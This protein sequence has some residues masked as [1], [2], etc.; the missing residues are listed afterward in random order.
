[1]A[2]SGCNGGGNDNNITPSQDNSNDSSHI[3]D[4]NH[5]NSQNGG[6]TGGNTGGNAGGNTGGNT[7]GNTG[8]NTSGNTGGD[9]GGNTGG[10]TGGNTGGDTGGNTGGDTGGNTG[11]NTGGDTGGNTGGDTGG[12]TGGDKDAIKDGHLVF[13]EELPTLANVKYTAAAADSQNIYLAVATTPTEAKVVVYNKNTKQFDSKLEIKSTSARPYRQ[14][15]S[16]DVNNG[17]L[18][19]VSNAY[20]RVDVYNAKD[21]TFIAALG[22][23]NLFDKAPTGLRRPIAVAANNNYVFVTSFCNYVDVYKTSD[24]KSSDSL[25]IKQ[26]SHLNLPVECKDECST[27]NITM[28]IVDNKL[29]V[30]VPSEGKKL[31]SY[32]IASLRSK[33]DVENCTTACIQPS[34]VSDNFYSSIAHN[35]NSPYLMTY[36][37]A[38]ISVYEANSFDVTTSK[39]LITAKED[40]KKKSFG[41]LVNIANDNDNV[42]A[43][44]K[45]SVQLDT[46]TK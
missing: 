34:S 23:G 46:Y 17:K 9:T 10:D 39:S 12:N 45:S 22:T 36:K 30:N 2:L 4:G 15:T 35:S 6:N 8:G 31:L 20:N 43:I 7:S 19:V 28:A 44:K 24:I 32:D 40:D 16:L 37:D 33:P 41:M 18:Y 25:K 42:I 13:A 11:G 26:Y 38:A 3:V 21:M 27:R 5:N 14:I 29:L 1:M